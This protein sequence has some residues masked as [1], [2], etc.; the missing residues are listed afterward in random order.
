LLLAPLAP[1]LA[2]YVTAAIVAYVR[3]KEKA[4]Q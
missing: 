3:A 4:R 1:L 2:L